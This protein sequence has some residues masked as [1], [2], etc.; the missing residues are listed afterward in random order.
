M[1]SPSCNLKKPLVAVYFM[2]S[3]VFQR[4]EQTATEVSV[5]QYELV[6]AVTIK[7]ILHY[8]FVFASTLF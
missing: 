8:Y 6:C 7:D 3:N 5:Y 1:I 2:G 4:T